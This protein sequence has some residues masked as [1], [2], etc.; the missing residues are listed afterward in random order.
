MNKDTSIRDVLIRRFGSGEPVVTGKAPGRVNLI[1][2]HTDYNEGYVLPMAI[3]FW[4]EMA[5]R[6]R[7]D[8]IVKV[9]SCDYDQVVAFSLCEPLL[10]DREHLWSNYIRGVCWALQEKGVPLQ[11]MELAFG[12]N[13][14]QGAG[15][16][17]SAALEVVTVMVTRALCGLELELSQ[18]AL[19]CQHAENEFVGIKCGAM[20]QFISVMGQEN[21]ALFLDCRTL[22][23]DRIPLKL[24]GYR[25]VI[26]HSGVRHQLVASEYNRRRKSCQ[27][28]VALIQ[29]DVPNIRALRD[30]N[31]AMLEQRRATLGPEVYRRCR[32]VVTENQRV[33]DSVQAL[34]QGELAR[35]GTLMNE[36]HDSQRDDFEVSCP[37]I[38]LLVDLAR[39]IPGVLGARITGGGFGG[40]TVN[41]VATTA[42]ESFTREVGRAYREQTGIEPCFF[43][44]MPVAGAKLI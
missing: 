42:V 1:G 25:V 8:A 7:P 11:G 17:S 31:L 10:Y 5:G 28:G 27:D 30:V 32:H 16:S 12:G 34:G 19:L 26:C 6:L 9:Y 39:R 18:I 20:D 3:N 22:K 36:S 33:L 43:C 29:K 14:P 23:F 35:F 41:L 21:R 13:I 4:I 44:C 40:C 37:E 24:G 38:D 15:L 2:E